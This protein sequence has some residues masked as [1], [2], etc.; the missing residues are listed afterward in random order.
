MSILSNSNQPLVAL[1]SSV[2]PIE[3]AAIALLAIAEPHLRERQV[4]LLYMHDRHKSPTFRGRYL[5][6][7]DALPLPYLV[8]DKERQVR[9]LFLP[10]GLAT[11]ECDED[12]RVTLKHYSRLYSTSH[13]HGLHELS[14][15]LDHLM[16]GLYNV[17]KCDTPVAF[18]RSLVSS[19]TSSLFI[20]PIEVVPYEEHLIS[21]EGQRASFAAL[22]C[23]RREMANLRIPASPG[24]RFVKSGHVLAST[25]S[26]QFRFDFAFPHPDRLVLR[27][28]STE[29]VM[30]L[31]TKSGALHAHVLTSSGQ[32]E[33]VASIELRGPLC[34]AY[35]RQLGVP[36]DVPWYLPEVQ[37]E[38]SAA[39]F[40][41]IEAI[42]PVSVSS[43]ERSFAVKGTSAL[44][45]Y[46]SGYSIIEFDDQCSLALTSM[47]TLCE[48][49][50]RPDELLDWR[51]LLDHYPRTDQKLLKSQ[52]GVDKYI[53]DR[54]REEYREQRANASIAETAQIV[55]ALIPPV[56]LGETL[57]RL[58]ASIRVHAA[59]G[60]SSPNTPAIGTAKLG[61]ITAIATEVIK[62]SRTWQ[63]RVLVDDTELSNAQFEA[64]PVEVLE[65]FAARRSSL[66]TPATRTIDRIQTTAQWCRLIEIELN[67]YYRCALALSGAALKLHLL[68]LLLVSRPDQ[69]HLFFSNLIKQ[70]G[71][72]KVIT[73]SAKLYN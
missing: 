51:R 1:I 20:K 41:G 40:V 47:L 32:I 7:H 25:A 3:L 21:A 66:E 33:A 30:E 59:S 14:H 5:S 42:S 13:F 68:N 45:L 55:P 46:P 64:N 73:L 39:A 17:A 38:A 56:C 53:A 29:A 19:L 71:E 11:G 24:F 27:G 61:S 12:L 34:L 72:K 9:Q 58:H 54:L 62:M 65:W 15:N 60:R 43:P 6:A 70:R 4:R 67:D 48:E 26:G 10:L 50:L 31:P 22:H 2:H 16:N 49:T 35:L 57:V 18:A 44:R 37:Q 52:S 8:R 36:V 63:Q 23:I 28:D 69:W